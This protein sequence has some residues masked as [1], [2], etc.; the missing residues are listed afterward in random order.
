MKCLLN[1]R[2]HPGEQLL[3]RGAF[4]RLGL[5]RGKSVPLPVVELPA[6]SIGNQPVHTAGNV[7]EV[8]TQR[9]GSTRSLPQQ[10]DWDSRRRPTQ[11][12]LRL[13]Q[14]VSYRL[15]RWRD[16]FD[17]TFEPE[18]ATHGGGFGGRLPRAADYGA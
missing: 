12:V 4:R 8:K 7:A 14:R 6:E 18:L 2:V 1:R 9:R 15:E 17:R 11:I 10:I 3:N 5:L 16:S 13:K